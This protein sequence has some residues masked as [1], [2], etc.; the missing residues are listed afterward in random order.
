MFWFNFNVKYKITIDKRNRVGKSLLNL[1]KKN[2]LIDKS[3]IKILVIMYP[4][5][6]KKI[7]TPKYPFS[8]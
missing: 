1:L 2:S 5:M 8:K 6:T 4:D 3:L 7:S